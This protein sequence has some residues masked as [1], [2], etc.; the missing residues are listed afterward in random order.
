MKKI[1]DGDSTVKSI[2]GAKK[3]KPDCVYRWSCFAVPYT[4]NDRQYIYNNFSKVCFEIEPDEL[5]LR[6]EARFTSEQTAA[7]KNLSALVSDLFLV[8]E[9]T[10]ETATYEKYAAMCRAMH[11]DKKGY[12]SYTILPTTACNARCF[13]CF[14][15]GMTFVTM[16]DEIVNQTIEFIKKTRNPEKPVKFTWFGGE[17]LAGEKIIDKICAAM[18]EANI[19]FKSKMISNGSLITE[20]IIQKMKNDWNLGAVQITLDGVEEEYNRRKNYAFNY[21]SAYWHV[22]SRIKLINE[23]GIRL[24]IRVNVDEGNIDGIPQMAEDLKNFIPNPELVSFGLTPLFDIHEVKDDLAVWQRSF[25]ISEQ[26]EA[27]G[28]KTSANYSI[29][30][31]KV[32]FCMADSPHR[33]VVIAPDGK[34]YP[35]EDISNIGSI[36]DIFEG[37]TN[38]ELVNSLQKPEKAREQCRGCFSLPDCTTFSRCKNRSASCRYYTRKR[39]EKA[40]AK[41]LDSMNDENDDKETEMIC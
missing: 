31:T 2:M 10:D 8:P 19:E 26:L 12:S 17:P 36:G 34:L 6:T 27:M 30:K 11:T 21:V 40:L 39:L 29:G 25:E 16:S 33:S 14:E 41:R 18:R 35:C 24:H 7:D 15:E 23:N 1:I 28:F 32:F 9:G 22:L 3:V 4:H 37:V 20:K 38:R 5:D 13:Y